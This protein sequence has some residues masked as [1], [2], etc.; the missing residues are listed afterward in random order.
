AYELYKTTKGESSIEVGTCLSTIATCY[1]ELG[2]FDKSLSTCESGIKIFS[3]LNK[4]NL[5]LD[6][7]SSIIKKY[8]S[9]LDKCGFDVSTLYKSAVNLYKETS[10]L[11]ASIKLLFL[12][13]KCSTLS[14]VEKGNCYS[15][16]ASCYR[17]L[18]EHDNAIR[19]CENAIEAF[20]IAKI[21]PAKKQ[22]LIESVKVKLEK[23]IN[24]T[25]VNMI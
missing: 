25:V 14:S 12:I 9:C 20:Q 15:T 17:E 21:N 11:A 4:K 13:K 24:P 5:A 7:M 3:E 18:D 6:E 16:L 22:E 19:A 2:M 8:N 1:R 23:L 10:Y